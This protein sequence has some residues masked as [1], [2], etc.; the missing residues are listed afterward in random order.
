[1]KRSEFWLAIV[2]VL[3]VLSI[4]FILFSFFCSMK[5]VKVNLVNAVS[6][7]GKHAWEFLIQDKE[8]P[9]GNTV[10]VIYGN[11]PISVKEFYS[12]KIVGTVNIGSLIRNDDFIIYRYFSAKDGEPEKI[13]IE[14]QHKDGTTTLI[15]VNINL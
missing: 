10:T 9:A 5:V 12:R 8:I 11:F 4:L 2:T 7:D 15:S 14:I 3:L 1:M 13:F 6:E